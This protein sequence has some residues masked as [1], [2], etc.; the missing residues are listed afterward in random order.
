L[1]NGQIADKISGDNKGGIMISVAPEI[2][3]PSQT[4]TYT[5]NGIEA[6][7]ST[8]LLPHS[9]PVCITVLYRSL[10]VPF[11]SLTNLLTTITNHTCASTLP[12]I[13]F[14]EDILHHSN[15]TIITFM[16][17]LGYAHH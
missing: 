6:I 7:S 15:P 9:T 14:I 11:Q 12:H 17:T 16:S 5:C 3:Q 2:I 8:S 4:H 1:Q 10:S 13:D